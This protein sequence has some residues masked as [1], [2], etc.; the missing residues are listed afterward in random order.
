MAAKGHDRLS[1]DKA[2]ERAAS[3]LTC[4]VA[5][6]VVDVVRPLPGVAEKSRL[7]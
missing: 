6:E 4:V 1:T 2:M 7:H 5:R 3:P